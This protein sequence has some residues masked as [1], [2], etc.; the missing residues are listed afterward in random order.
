[1]LEGL[2][3]AKAYQCRKLTQIQK[4]ENHTE[5]G[6]CAVHCHAQVGGMP[7]T[8]YWFLGPAL[9]KARPDVP[10]YKRLTDLILSAPLLH[11]AC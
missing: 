9:L 8:Q 5:E 7:G 11:A 4:L 1:M 6:E 10:S 2:R 3:C